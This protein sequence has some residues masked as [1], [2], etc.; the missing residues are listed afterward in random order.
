GIWRLR[1]I[2]R[3]RKLNAPSIARSNMSND[4]AGKPGLLAQPMVRGIAIAAVVVVIAAAAGAYFMRS[5]GG[6]G[7]STSPGAAVKV[8]HSGD[9]GFVSAANAAAAREAGGICDRAVTRA[10]SFA[11]LPDGS[12]ASGAEAKGEAEGHFTCQ[13]QS[14]T[15]GTFTLVVRQSCDD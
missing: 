12:K 9:E 5:G 2:H 4:E 6:S 11:V 13:A 3:L 8:A 15:G 7:S 10:Q 1:G 14:L